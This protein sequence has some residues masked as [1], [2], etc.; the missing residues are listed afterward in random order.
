MVPK[1]DKK[2]RIGI[3]LTHLSKSIHREKHPFLAVEQSLVQLAGSRV[4]QL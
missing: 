4:F 3:D 2:V 1:G